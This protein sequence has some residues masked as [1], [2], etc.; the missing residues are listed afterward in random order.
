MARK[1]EYRATD[2]PGIKQR[3]KDGKYLVVIDLGR[4]PRLDKKTGEIVLTQCKT[5]KIFDTLKEAKA[6]QGA[7]DAVKKENKVTKVA[8]K[9]TFHQAIADYNAKY[10]SGWGYSYAAQKANQVRRMIAY[11]GDTDVRKIDTLAIEA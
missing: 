1:D 7:N 2:R 4:Q 10:S 5:Q 6:Y 9:V 11:F 3:I 8:G